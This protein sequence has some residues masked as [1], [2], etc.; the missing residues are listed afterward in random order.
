MPKH[1]LS[2]HPPL[3]N[4]AGTLGFAPDLHSAVDWS[5]L[6]AFITNPVSLAPRTPARGQ[7]FTV[8]PGGYLLHTGYPNPGLSHV[9]RH[10][11]SHWK[12]SPIPVVVHLFTRSAEELSE[13]VQ[14]LE[15]LDGVTGLEIGVTSEA[16]ADSVEALV[17]AASGELPVIMRLPMEGAA[18]LAGIAIHSG[19]TAISL[20]PP[21]G[22]LPSLSGNL[23]QGRLYG[24]AIFPLALRMTHELSQ[25][26]IPIIAAGGVTT[27]QDVEA[28]LAAGAMAVQLDSAL[29][30][31]AGY[32]FLA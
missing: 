9:I 6:G 20:A 4:A 2:L 21:R 22:E 30:R 12:R 19:A 16:D 15:A 24:P 3:M 7:R 1:D 11:A 18:E 8:F 13:M 31:D 25:Q 26:S 17:Q 28:M 5:R 10:Y 29:W 32:N 14:R 23:N 27:R